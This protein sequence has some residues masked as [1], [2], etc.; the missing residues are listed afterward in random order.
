MY[1]RPESSWH[2]F[3]HYI[4]CFQFYFSVFVSFYS[5]ADNY[6]LQLLPIFRFVTGVKQELLNTQL[7]QMI[8]VPKH[9]WDNADLELY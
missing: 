1:L 7:I 8:Y 2:L 9:S 4:T 6:Q 3:K 5:V